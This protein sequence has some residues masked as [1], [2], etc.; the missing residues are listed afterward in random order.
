MTTYIDS[1]IINLNSDKAT[2]YNNGTDLSNLIFSFPALLKSEDNILNCQ[3]G[4]LNAQF[5]VS[6]YIINEYN[7]YL[8][9]IHNGTTYNLYVP[10]GNYNSS[11]LSSYLQ[12][13]M[14][15]DSHSNWTISISKST[16][17]FTFTSTQAFILK[18]NISTIAGILGMS[19]TNNNSTLISP[20]TL[21]CPY[22]VNLLGIKKLKISSATLAVNSA[23]SW[24][25]GFCN[26]IG[27]IPVNQPSYGLIQY[28]NQGNPHGNLR[29]KT[30]DLIDIQV[31][32]EFNNLVN[33]NN[34]NWTLSLELII[35]RQLTITPFNF[36][37]QDILQQ[38]DDDTEQQQE[39]DIE[40]Q[41]DTTQDTTQ[42]TAPTDDTDIQPS[43]INNDGSVINP[44]INNDLDLLLY[45]N[46]L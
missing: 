18:G 10:Y 3:L 36:P 2:T 33:F 35:L 8:Q 6:F 34:V 40:Q 30:I 17:L 12:T 5:P 25:G 13:T 7:N 24:A 19:K 38:Q 41:Q 21:T 22:P 28:M 16:G 39:D 1:R 32:D 37:T 11:T 42:D 44:D 26:I 29:S 27:T 20:Y 46:Q 45:N 43:Y 23:D 31:L 15:Y 14:T 4:I 9:Y